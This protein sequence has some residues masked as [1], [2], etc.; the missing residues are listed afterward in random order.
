M[1]V[2]IV[3]LSTEALTALAAGDLAAAT[4]LS[5]VP[6][7]PWHVSEDCSWVW[8]YRAK[9]AVETPGDLPW[10]TGI[11][12]DESAGVAVGQSGFHGAPDADGMVEVGYAVDPAY[13]RRGYARAALEL[14]IERAR[15]EPSV[16]TLRA[17]ISPENEASLALLA[18]YPFVR[19]GEQWDEEDGL[20]LIFELSV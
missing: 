13:R 16:R 19:N 12:W 14:A 18:Q 17:T 15:L 10:I 6:L 5:P 7:S 2:S 11:L 4:A 8:Q 1:T 9:Q 3:R 20:E